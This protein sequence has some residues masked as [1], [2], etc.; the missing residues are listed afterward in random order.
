MKIQVLSDLHLEFERKYHGYES[1]ADVMV[2]A[3]DL[4]VY[5]DIESSLIKFY[6]IYNKPII[7]VPG[8]HEYYH[9]SKK[10]MDKV[11][12]NFDHPNIHILNGTDWVNYNGVI[13]IG[14]TGW[15][16]E[17]NGQVYP[18]VSRMSDYHYIDDIREN[19]NGVDWGI[20]SKKY[21]QSCLETFNKFKIV[22]VSHNGVIPLVSERFKGSALNTCFFNNWSDLLEIYKPSLWIH[23]H[24]HDSIDTTVYNTRIICN[25]KGYH[26]ENKNFNPN[27]IVEV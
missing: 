12:E 3:G 25:P 22:C 21:F 14:S 1:N 11:F 9:S 24:T 15:W 5:N 16:D 8:N 27:L 10:I 23:G 19:N 17:S 26:S 6:E 20:K 13:F 7:F 4:D 18:Y 2:I